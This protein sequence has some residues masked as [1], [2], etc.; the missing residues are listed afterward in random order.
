VEK[1]GPVLELYEQAPVLA[2]QG[3]AVCCVDEKT[4]IQ[5]HQRVSATKGAIPQYPMPVADRYRRMGAIH[6]F[7]AVMVAT[8]MTVA[9]CL[10]KRGFADFKT[11]LLAV[12]ASSA[13][14]GLKVLHLILDNGS[15]HAPKQLAGWIASLNLSFEVHIYWLPKYASWLDQVEIIFS[16]VQRDVLTPNDFPSMTALICDLVDYSGELNQLPNRS[17][18][19]IPRSNG[20]QNLGPRRLINWWRNYGAQYLGLFDRCV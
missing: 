15:T 9:Q 10:L 11:S 12:F 2:T 4:S 7:C 8:G 16:N 19:W 20:S 1:A 13:Y 14:Q 17:S 3:E 6:L 18:G 5:A